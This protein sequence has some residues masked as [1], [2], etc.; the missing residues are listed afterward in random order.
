MTLFSIDQR[1]ARPRQMTP[2]LAIRDT[3]GIAKRNLL[4]I[5]RTPLM[6]VVTAIQPALLLA[7]FRYVWGALTR[8]G[9]C[10]LQ[11]ADG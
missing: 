5:I 9:L 10:D 1:G 8:P 6:H 7:L 3:V 4:R 11:F 2:R